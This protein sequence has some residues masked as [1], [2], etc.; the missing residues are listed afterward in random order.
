MNHEK[1]LM[2]IY[3]LVGGF[4]SS[5]GCLKIPKGPPFQ[6]FRHCETFSK[7]FFH[8]RD[9]LPNDFCFVPGGAKDPGAPG[10]AGADCAPPELGSCG[11]CG[12]TA[13]TAGG[14][15]SRAT[16]AA[17]TAPSA[18][19]PTPAHAPADGSGPGSRRTG[20]SRAALAPL[21]RHRRRA[22]PVLAGR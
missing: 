1:A 7:T 18:L 2:S 19:T 9:P 8:Q 10:D 20:R 21:P 14:A 15:P 17:A 11:G 3:G 13:A 16:T 22:A 5:K 12:P 4:R 6:F